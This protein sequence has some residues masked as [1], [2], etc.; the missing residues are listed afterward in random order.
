MIGDIQQDQSN[1]FR[2]QFAFIVAFNSTTQLFPKPVS[3]KSYFSSRF[4]N[5][6]TN[7]TSMEIYSMLLL[8][9]ATLQN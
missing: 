1:I 9:I 2:D 6:N 8:R 5:T 4:C 7:I 3:C